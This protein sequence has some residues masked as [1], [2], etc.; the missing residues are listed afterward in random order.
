MKRAQFIFNHVLRLL[1]SPVEV[2]THSFYQEPFG[3]SEWKNGAIGIR[4]TLFEYIKWLYYKS[5]W[6]PF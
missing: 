1:E 3:M 2:E 4:V 5:V 6:Q